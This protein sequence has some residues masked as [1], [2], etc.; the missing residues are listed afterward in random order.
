[1]AGAD[2]RSPA[3]S[4][5]FRR[6]LRANPPGPLMGTWGNGLAHGGVAA[7]ADLATPGANL[8]EPRLPAYR[9]A[10]NCGGAIRA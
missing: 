7:R 5:A 3:T 1:M 8:R 2:T 6:Q 4:A 9:P 10:C